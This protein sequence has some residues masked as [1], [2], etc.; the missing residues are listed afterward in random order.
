MNLPASISQKALS[1]APKAKITCQINI[2]GKIIILYL[3]YGTKTLSQQKEKCFSLPR[4]AEV[5]HSGYN[6]TSCSQPFAF[7]PSMHHPAGYTTPNLRPPQ[8]A[9]RKHLKTQVVLHLHPHTLS[10]HT[11]TVVSHQTDKTHAS[12]TFL[13]HLS[14]EVPCS[15]NTIQGSPISVLFT[16]SHLK[17]T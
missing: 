15:P 16:Y 7:T 5:L 8:T 6:Y 13:F 4:P 10:Q 14:F 1:S 11:H 3:K 2:S 9:L 17:Y 12:F